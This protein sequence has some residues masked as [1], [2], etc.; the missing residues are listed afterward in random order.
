MEQIVILVKLT[1]REGM[2]QQLANVLSNVG[3]VAETEPG[4]L[5]Y[6]LMADKADSCVLWAYHVYADQAAFE[7]HRTSPELKAA[8][9]ALK[10]FLAHDYEV[11]KTRPLGG[12]NV[13]SQAHKG[14][15]PAA[16][17]VV[18]I[19][20]MTAREGTRPK[21]VEVMK[22]LLRVVEEEQGTLA[23][24]LLADTKDPEVLWEYQV[25]ANQKVFEDHR[26]APALKAIQ[27]AVKPHLVGNAYDVFKTTPL[28]G[29]GLA[30]PA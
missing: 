24:L 1:A 20:K 29:K 6:V 9:L 8:Q 21:V 28:G 10:P 30:A 2:R 18:A 13:P 27:A 22:D 26:V 7:I 14:S 16:D 15:H 4:T 23:F 5:A 11:I 17:Q 25:Y 3:E 19:V 12:K